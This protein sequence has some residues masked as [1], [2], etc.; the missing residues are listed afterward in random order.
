M[1][2]AKLCV[3]E[4]HAPAEIVLGDSMVVGRSSSADFRIGEPTVSRKH[5]RFSRSSDGY[6]V[7]NLSTGNGTQVNREMIHGE[8]VL[9]DGD[10]IRLG[11]VVLRFEVDAEASESQTAHDSTSFMVIDDSGSLNAESV[12]EWL[13]AS[14][15]E[16]VG[17]AT[18][19]HAGA[20]LQLLY[21]VGEQI[22]ANFD[23]E[24]IFRTV[25][26]KLFDVFPQASS[27]SVVS[28]DGEADE[29]TP[30]L[31]LDNRGEE[32]NVLI[33]QSLIRGVIE[34]KTGVLTADA[35]D[36]ERFSAF[37]TVHQLKMRTV[38]CVPMIAGDEV[39]GVL[40]LTGDDPRHTFVRDDMVLLLG[41][42]G[43][44]AL[45]VSNARLHARLLQR[46]L[47]DK[48][49]ALAN[50]VQQ[51]FLPSEPPD[52]EGYAFWHCYSPAL[53]VG[54][55]YFGY[56]DLVPG[57]VGIAAGDVS[58]KGVSAALFM[59]RV[60]G[61][62]RYRAAGLKRPGQ[63]LELLNQVLV[64]DAKEGMFITLVL[65]VVETSTRL[66]RV[67]NAGHHAPLVRGLSGSVVELELPANYPLGVVPDAE[68]PEC[69]FYLDP[70]DTVMLYTDGVNEAENAALE[71][72][73]EDQLRQT[74]AD[75]KGRPRDV[76]D[77]VLDSVKGF[78]GDRAQNDDI[79][80]VC[81]GPGGG[82]D[83]ATPNLA[84]A[85]IS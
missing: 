56:L 34:Q 48:D 18:S 20:R 51:S 69:A 11:D 21:D 74:I 2:S 41:V 37:E 13:K 6:V 84:G 36:D 27:G 7:E 68:F 66:L 17:T 35:L 53:E 46:Q 16:M 9:A 52:V 73:G 30:R 44:V 10:E 43:Q 32:I 81:F 72:Y 76:A 50:K 65:C 64:E 49:M 5:A 8:R 42:A 40:Q 3:L 70:G 47:V 77:S 28:Y 75:S 33:S 12:V 25:L 23:E 80:I 15:A 83:G 4:G 58:G 78:I 45:A 31:S 54:G 79:T 1:S 22:G 85:L 61:E 55:D 67:A 59:A 38:L 62:V 57:Y 82:E 29:L 39:F 26:T 24:H 14:D 19:D 71:Q 60:S 63:I